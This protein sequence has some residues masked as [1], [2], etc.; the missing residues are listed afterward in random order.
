MNR[1]RRLTLAVLL[2][3]LLL[4][5]LA[6]YCHRTE[7]AK[8]PLPR[9]PYQLAAFLEEKGMSFRLVA[10][11][12]AAVHFSFGRA[13][14][15]IGNGLHKTDRTSWQGVV[16]CCKLTSENEESEGPHCFRLGPLLFF[17]DPEILAKVKKA[18]TE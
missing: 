6:S 17:G 7:L 11:S 9:T 10:H 18:L 1:T 5:A 14:S 12:P 8:R 13:L 2:P 16:L 3:L 4:V 15:E